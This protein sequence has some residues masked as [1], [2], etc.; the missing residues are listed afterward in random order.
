MLRYSDNTGL[1]IFKEFF[2][3]V[4]MLQARAKSEEQGL[5]RP[6]NACKTKLSF[7]LSVSDIF[8]V[9]IFTNVTVWESLMEK[10]LERSTFTLIL[11]Q[12][13]K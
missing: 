13:R 3:L 8:E 6:G 4:D 2:Q 5:P 11:N 7:F 1:A 12:R 10:A 9:S